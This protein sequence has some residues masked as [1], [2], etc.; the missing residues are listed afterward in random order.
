MT[1][2]AHGIDENADTRRLTVALALIAGFMLGRG[3][4]RDPRPLPRAALGR[5]AHA[6]RRR[7][8]RH[9]PPATADAA[10][11]AAGNLTF[12]LERSEILSAQA[13]GGTGGVGLRLRRR[14][15]QD[16][17]E[18]RHD[19]HLQHGRRRQGA[20][21]A[22]GM[23]GHSVT[24]LDG[25][26]VIREWNWTTFHHPDGRERGADMEDLP[27]CRERSSAAGGRLTTPTGTG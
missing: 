3:R 5:G 27:H 26:D 14:G 23:G 13:N 8:P 24:C 15:Q 19:A 7:R 25:R 9:V 11:L 18:R 20:A 22:A 21:R 17:A 4:G 1:G 16:D 12:G 2:H 6:H 10:S